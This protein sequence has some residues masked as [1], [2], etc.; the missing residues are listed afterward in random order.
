MAATIFS[1]PI[2]NTLLRYTSKIILKLVGWSVI[3]ETPTAEK[4]VVIGA[5]HT[6]NW[7]FILMMVAVFDRRLEVHWMGKD[8]LFPWPI[9]GFMHWLGGI[10]IDRSQSNNTVDQVVEHFKS[11]SD[12]I[13]IIPPEGTR[14]KAQRWKTGF[15]HIAYGAN[16]P[17][18]LAAIDATT[19]TVCFGPAFF[20]TGDIE[21]D[22]PE[23]QLFYKDKK[24]INPDCF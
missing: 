7:D 17:I 21:V 12:L 3:G 16:V 2:I 15:Y 13:V 23:I 19:K 24:G 14:S 9:K 11:H 22:L 18:I 10:A 1:T 5:P 6:S 20:P 8:S 4:Y